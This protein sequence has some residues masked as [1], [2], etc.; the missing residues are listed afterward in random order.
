MSIGDT[1]GSARARPASD[2]RSRSTRTSSIN[3]RADPEYVDQPDDEAVLL[4]SPPPVRGI[5]AGVVDPFQPPEGD[6]P[7][8]ADEKEQIQRGERPCAQWV[9]WQAWITMRDE[10]VCPECGPLHGQWF[11]RGEG[12]TP[13]LHS[14][15]R[16]ERRNVHRE[17]VARRAGGAGAGENF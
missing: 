10:R 5:D 8:P 7:P 15:C 2:S 6:G 13:P 4:R 1:S 12:P 9:V 3:G 17:C 11:R 14:G 16:C